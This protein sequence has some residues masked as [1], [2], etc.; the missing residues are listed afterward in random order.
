MAAALM[1]DS[2]WNEGRYAAQTIRRLRA[3]ALAWCA[4]PPSSHFYRQRL[5]CELG[6]SSLEDFLE[7]YWVATFTAMDANNLLCQS[8]T[9]L[10][11]DIS[12]NEQFRGDFAAALRSISA[13]ALI[14]PSSSD[15]YFPPEDSALEA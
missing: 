6:Y 11:A 15:A 1:A 12:R 5:Y 10:D 2:A 13:R 8:H 3:M 9:W 7:R 14:M 4:W